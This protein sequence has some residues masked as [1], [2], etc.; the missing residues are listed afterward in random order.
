MTEYSGNRKEKF[1]AY[2][3]AGYGTGLTIG[4]V[5]GGLIYS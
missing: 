2:I 3:E 4:P 5:L 1:M